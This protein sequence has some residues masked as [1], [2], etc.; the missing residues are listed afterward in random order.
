[1]ENDMSESSS[2][3]RAL[4]SVAAIYHIADGYVGGGHYERIKLLAK[5]AMNVLRSDGA[6]CPSIECELAVA[7]SALWEHHTE[8]QKSYKLEEQIVAVLGKARDRGIM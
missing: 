7:L 6:A 4:E 3:Q 1:M 5:N 8:G 2:N